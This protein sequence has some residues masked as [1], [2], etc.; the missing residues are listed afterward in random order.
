MKYY[1]LL[2]F[3]ALTW[4]NNLSAQTDT[5]IYDVV[6]QQPRFPMCES[7]DTTIAA[8]NQC[9]Q[10]ALLAIIYQN[11]QY[12]VQARMEGLEGT[13]VASFVVEP[14]STVSNAQVLRDIGGGCGNAVV[15][16]INAMNVA[17]IRW[18]PGQRVGKDVRAKMTVPIK[19]RLQEA[20]PYVLME[21]DTVYTQLEKT[22][23]FKEGDEGLN[24][25]ITESLKY[26]AA[27][28]DTCLFG[29]MDVQ[30]L[31]EP[32]GIV[33]SIS[34]SD[35]MELGLDF[36]LEVVNLI[37]GMFGKWNPATY[38][39]REVPSAVE[40]RLSFI[41]EDAIACQ[42][43]IENFQT[44]NTLAAEG[45]QLYD[46]GEQES[47]LEK[48][49]KA[50]ELLPNNAEYLAFRGQAYVDQE[51]YRAA[52]QDLFQVR[53]ILGTDTYD[54]LLMI[55]CRMEEQGEEEK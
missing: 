15:A 4:Q 44:A 34:I 21:G 2:L 1:I 43:T 51:D 35:Y 47:G 23:E 55:V 46:S 7:L 17:G 28:K 18:I 49:S 13:V 20:P 41:P 19:F 26:P 12:P 38:K 5:I 37:T 29:Y 9:A 27:Y 24:T 16:V 3:A 14:D 33:K 8:K 53:R 22:A 10:Q 50:I 40:I 30:L 32:D 42:A 31:I 36:Q 6:E 48:L 54:Q 45:M 52:C 39:G 25:F 11:V